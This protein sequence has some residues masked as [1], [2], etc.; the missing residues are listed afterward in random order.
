MSQ[1]VGHTDINLGESLWLLA[2]R[3]RPQE[4]LQTHFQLLASIQRAFRLQLFLHQVSYS[5][6]AESPWHVSGSFVVQVVGH[7][8]VVVLS[9]LKVVR[10]DPG[11]WPLPVGI[12][13]L[14]PVRA[15]HLVKV[16]Y[17]II[18]VKISYFPA[19]VY[20]ATVQLS[21]VTMRL[22]KHFWVVK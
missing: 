17:T 4:R 5:P 15:R 19:Q 20:D 3:K 10:V 9:D 12:G 11:H 14:H 18:L 13:C 16:T 21:K 6:E 7:G 2:F 1:Q 22:I 8:Q